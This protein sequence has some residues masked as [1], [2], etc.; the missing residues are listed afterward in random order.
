LNKVQREAMGARGRVLAEKKWSLPTIVGQ[1][2]LLYH[3]MLQPRPGERRA[4]R[5]LSYKKAA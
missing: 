1:T 5:P 4:S 3:E 2:L